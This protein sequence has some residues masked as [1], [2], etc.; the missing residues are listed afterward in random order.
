MPKVIVND[1]EIEV[2]NGASALDAV[3]QAGFDVPYFCSNEYLSPIGACRMCLVE[4]GSPRKNPDGTWIMDDATGKPKLFFFPGTVASCTLATSEGMVIKT[5]SDAAV[6][7]QAGM[8][9]FTLINHPLDCPTCDKGGAC[10]L[11]DRAYEYGYGEARFE[12]TRRHADKHHALSDFI[13]LDKERCIHCKRCV[14]YFEEIPGEEVLDFIER[15]GHTFIDSYQSEDLAGAKLGNFSGNINDLC[16]VGAL[17]DNVSRFRGRNWEYD[18]TQ[19]TD[20]SNADGASI[21]VDARTGRIERIRAAHNKEVNEIWISDAQRFGHE[22]VDADARVRT[23]LVRKNGKL[24]PATFEEAVEVIRAKNPEPSK[25]GLYTSA[26]ITLEEGVALES[27]AKTLSTTNVDHFPRYN[28]PLGSVAR[29]T[30]TDLAKADAVVV[31]GADLYEESGTSYLRIEES[32][33]GVLTT[34]IQYKHGNALADLRLKERMDRKRSKLAV[35][36]PVPVKQMSHAGIVGL[37]AVGGELE[38]IAQIA[39]AKSGNDSSNSAANAAG[40]LLA[41]AKNPVVVLGSFALAFDAEKVLLAAKKLGGKILPIPAGANGAGLENFEL[42]PGKNGRSFG[43]WDGLKAIFVSGTMLQKRPKDA[44]LLVVHTHTLAGAA[45]E[46]DVVL[47]ASTAYEKR[48]TTMNLEGRLLPLHGAAVDGGQSTDLIGALQI[49]SEAM[50]AKLEVRGT[51]SAQR[52]LQDKFGVDVSSLGLEGV[53]PTRGIGGK[54]ASVVR[55]SSSDNVL[56][57]PRMWNEQM[58]SSGRIRQS[59]GM[60]VLSV[61]S[62]DATRLGVRDGYQVEVEVNGK[63][64]NVVVRLD[65]SVTAPTLPALGTDLPGALAGVKIAVMAGGDD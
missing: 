4:A 10:E 7:A 3:F 15:G 22:W 48:G 6:K 59:V 21:W 56:L 47:P 62:S 2:P 65:E 41:G 9:E 19:T 26:D 64:R 31:I 60:D 17:L 50:N 37:Y 43:Q 29:A 40:Q 27:F 54:G 18:R 32:L 16:P 39:Q 33:K 14:R 28:A 49:L 8:M 11:Q 58:L 20:L 63:A 36:A 55:S 38:F 23:P 1:R 25:I 35:F 34:D 30:F 12:F 5:L 61:N 52:I 51:R 24:E 44:E 45:L 42:V 13:V 57:V 53:F 46:A